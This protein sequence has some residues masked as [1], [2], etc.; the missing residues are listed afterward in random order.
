MPLPVRTTLLALGSSG[1]KTDTLS[2]SGIR[3]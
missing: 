2:A 1:L 3:M